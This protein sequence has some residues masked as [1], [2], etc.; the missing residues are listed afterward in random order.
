MNEIEKLLELLEINI[1][2][3]FIDNLKSRLKL[4]PDSNNLISRLNKV[5][6]LINESQPIN[7]NDEIICKTEL[8]SLSLE[9]L[10][11]EKE[12]LLVKSNK[13]HE[14]YIKT[15]NEYNTLLKKIKNNKDDNLEKLE[16]EVSDK[17]QELKELESSYIFSEY[18]NINKKH[19]DFEKKINILKQLVNDQENEVIKEN[20]EYSKLL[21]SISNPSFNRII[22]INNNMKTNEDSEL[23]KYLNLNGK[24]L[25]AKFYSAYDELI[26]NHL[27]DETI[28]IIDWECG[29]AL[30]SS[31][32]ID[33]IREKDIVTA[34]SN[35]III[36]ESCLVLSRGLLHIDVIKDEEYNIKTINKNIDKI[37]D[38]DLRINNLNIN[39]HLFSDIFDVDNFVLDD[40]CEKIHS[41]YK[42][43]NYFVCISSNKNDN[44]D[45]FYDY[46]NDN[47][48]LKLISKRDENIGDYS[49]Y[50]R[51]FKVDI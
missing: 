15:K 8:A 16:F 20:S 5:D 50:E 46:F 49:R 47:F 51:I 4:L 24:A 27:Q 9:V 30:A 25:K 37:N 29:Q 45:G 7:S 22:Q 3:N 18:K 23:I 44:L 38:A 34:I 40:L 42:N 43:I 1:S 48:D 31:I 28:N 33:Y 11:L 17:K 41:N 35:I 32:L 36:D 10:S 13:K 6:N 2:N 21:Y 39:L 19:E 12:I 14:K 26:E